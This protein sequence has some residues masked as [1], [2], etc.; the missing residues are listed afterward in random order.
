LIFSDEFLEVCEHEF[1]HVE[2]AAL[3]DLTVTG[4]KLATAM[5]S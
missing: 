2:G 1:L 5:A 3:V 4:S